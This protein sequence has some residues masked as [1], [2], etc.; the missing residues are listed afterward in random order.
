MVNPGKKHPL[1]RAIKFVWWTVALY[2]SVS[3]LVGVIRGTFFEPD[4]R[5]PAAP[6]APDKP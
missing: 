5:P 1:Y 6:A 4:P 3:V 2:L